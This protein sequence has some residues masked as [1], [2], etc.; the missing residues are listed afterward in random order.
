MR[1]SIFIFLILLFSCQPSTT[2]KES[3]SQTEAELTQQDDTLISKKKPVE[4]KI[5]IDYDSSAWTDI[6]I[7]DSSILLDIRYATPFNFVEEK[8][9][10]CGRCF[11][12]K[13]V[14]QKIQFVHKKLQ[15]EGL[16]LKMFDCYRPRPIQWKLWEKVPDPRY[17]ADPRKGSMHNRGS[18]IDLTI[19]D[20]RGSE[21]DMGTSF[22]YFGREA[23]HSYTGH[24]EGIL[25]NRKKLKSIM[26]ENGFR[27]TSTEWWHY[28]Y[29]LKRYELSD[30][31]WNC[32]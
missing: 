11:L 25:D 14:A 29:R 22:D 32:N 8:M 9:Y 27:P 21:L 31:I 6:H 5:V 16:G 17:V 18:A 3:L 7:M 2:P 10:D 15:E 28:S 24:S 23:Y 26:E 20:A 4:K 30:W 12:R 1:A 19:V 13:E